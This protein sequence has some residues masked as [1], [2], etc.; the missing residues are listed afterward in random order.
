MTNNVDA[1][2]QNEITI[3]YD[4][5]GSLPGN[6]IT[7]ELTH[8]VNEPVVW[9]TEG[10]FFGPSLSVVGTKVSDST[11]AV[12]QPNVDYFYSPV[13]GKQMEVLGIPIYSYILLAD[14][15]KWSHITIGYQAVGC[16]YDGVLQQQIISLGNFDRTDLTIWTGLNGDSII[17]SDDIQPDVFKNGTTIFILAKK[18]GALA[19]SQQGPNTVLN[20]LKR[21]LVNVYA[22]LGGLKTL[23]QAW[24]VDI[25][26]S[27]ILNSFA[28]GTIGPVGPTGPSGGPVGPTGNTGPTGPS[29]GPTGPTGNTGPTGPTG[30]TGDIGATGPTGNTGVTGPIGNTGPTGNTGNTG[31]TGP[32]GIGITGPTGPG[33]G[34]T[35]PTG[36]TGSTGTTGPTGVTGSTGP[37][38]I[39]GLAQN[40]RQTVLDGPIDPTTGLPNFG[41]ATGGTS[42]TINGP[43]LVTAAAGFGING[44]I[45]RLG[46]II[47][48]TWT[49]LSTNG[50]MY[51]EL[52]INIDN[53]CNPI[54]NGS[55][56]NYIPFGNPAITINKLT[57][58]YRRMIGYL[59]DGTTANQSYRVCVGEVFVAGGIVQTITWYGLNGEYISAD[60]PTPLPGTLISFNHNLG[61]SP[62]VLPVVEWIC[63]N[64]ENG[65]NPGD[66][67]Q[68]LTSPAPN[69]IAPIMPWSRG[70]ASGFATGINGTT[71]IYTTSLNTN[72]LSPCVAD[73][74]VFRIRQDRGF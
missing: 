20:V 4:P 3:V 10:P 51:L 43:L 31:P 25:V 24:N 67:T 23:I 8:P 42:V 72:N 13:F 49:G 61:V 55:A 68:M 54:T 11:T 58:N 38:G 35:G 45:D 73:N 50:K 69:V 60:T 15:T 66:Q 29:D 57:F 46:T 40:N 53:T 36:N 14:Y 18:L 30:D 28:E 64:S 7:N 41:G 52:D 74:W 22:E 16:E 27:G 47:N 2:V 59:G 26:Q 37:T 62:T 12:L 65:F 44:P 1:F 71:A 56:P 34:A 63:K 70:N 33:V 21:E 19:N 39:S 48:P 6:T 17:N 5:T 9:T 32:T